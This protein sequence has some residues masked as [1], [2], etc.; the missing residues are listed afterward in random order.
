MGLVKFLRPS[1][2]FGVL[3][4]RKMILII[5]WR[6]MPKNWELSF[7]NRMKDL[8]ARGVP[9]HEFLRDNL[10]FLFGEAPSEIFRAWIGKKS[11]IYPDQFA[12]TVAKMFGSSAKSIITGLEELADPDRLTEI[13]KTEEPPYQ[14]LI[15]AIARSEGQVETR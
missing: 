10:P 1:F 15:E 7:V 2:T 3:Q 14:S 11:R 4:L 9:F 8:E 5:Q 13:H 6:R 12:R